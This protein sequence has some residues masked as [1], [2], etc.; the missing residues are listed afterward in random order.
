MYILF[1]CKHHNL[2]AVCFSGYNMLVWW[3]VIIGCFLSVGWPAAM[4][5]EVA[6]C[7]AAS[8]IYLRT[9]WMPKPEGELYA[10]S[11]N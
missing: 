9:G 5:G 2:F 4:S 3:F 7:I 1:I 6:L 8:W 11:G 10:C